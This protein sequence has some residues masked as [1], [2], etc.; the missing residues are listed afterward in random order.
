[1]RNGS[2]ATNS[3]LL[4]VLVIVPQIGKVKERHH[5]L[6]N[7]LLPN[8]SHQ[9]ISGDVTPVESIFKLEIWGQNEATLPCKAKNC[10]PARPEYATIKCLQKDWP[11]KP[12]TYK[13]FAQ[14]VR[15]N[16]EKIDLA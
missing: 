7:P 15:G 9:K 13:S 6:V 1:M 5:P 14:H 4:D 16:L 11:Q 8:T 3:I 12:Y 10:R 2:Y